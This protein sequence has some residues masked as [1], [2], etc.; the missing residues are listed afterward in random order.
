MRSASV[1]P[2]T[3]G[4]GRGFISLRYSYSLRQRRAHR[5]ISTQDNPPVIGAKAQE[6]ISLE[7]RKQKVHCFRTSVD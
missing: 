2:G 1:F 5:D 6:L 3:A 7:H 4:G